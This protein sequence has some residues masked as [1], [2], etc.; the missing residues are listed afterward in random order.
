MA[1]STTVN[2]ANPALL[3]HSITAEQKGNEY[4]FD[5]KVILLVLL[6]PFTS[7]SLNNNKNEC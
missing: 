7:H 2:E 3:H 6:K 5:L 4:K 1:A